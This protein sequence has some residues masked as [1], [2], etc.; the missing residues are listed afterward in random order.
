MWP[1]S[2]RAP[3]VAERIEPT[4]Q[5]T[6]ENPNVP[7]NQESLAIIIGGGPTMAGPHVNERSSL[8]NVDVFRCV[9]ILSGIVASLDLN[10]YH[11]QPAGRE[12][13]T[14]H[15]VF[16]FLHDAP[17]DFMT[18]FSWKELVMLHCLLWGNHYSVIEYDN[19]ARVVGFVPL[20]PWQVEPFRRDN[21]TIAYKVRLDDGSEIVES[22]D[23]LH[24]P[25]IGFDGLR[26]LSVISAVGRQAIGTSLAMEEFTA[27]LHSNGVKPSGIGKA[28]EG[29]SPSSFN[30][31]RQ[32]FEN[33]YS[34]SSNAGKTLWVDSGT[35]WQ[36]VQMSPVD[37]ETLA[38]RR[39]STAQICNIF[40]VPAML[41]NEN[42]DMTAWGAGIEQIMLGFQIT[43]INPWLRR[44]ENEFNRKLFLGT[45][46]RAE[47]EREGLI[48][49]D[50]KAKAELYSKLVANALM[51]PNEGLK[52][53]NLPSAG[54]AGDKLYMQGAM[55]SLDSIAEAEATSGGQ[56]P[57]PAP[58]QREPPQPSD[59]RSP[60]P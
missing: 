10:I 40:G 5:A 46:Y 14:G 4:I 52:K 39:Y 45:R 54:P 27:R 23:M 18:A 28:K 19:A 32:Q 22:E 55:R 47:Y 34:G 11:L 31:M 30:R 7:I 6:L 36:A 60:K 50:A 29:I 42:A 24:I 21:G 57:A 43:T 20:L 33:F 44:M 2:R 35:E 16:P 17:N 59:P 48:V 12:L 51:R 13:A 3:E 49:M 53:F 38:S 26:G 56:K 58:P 41:L 1:F 25:G 9:S 37:A 8:R 15:R